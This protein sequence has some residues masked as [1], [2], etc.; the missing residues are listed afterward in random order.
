[1]KIKT[2]W[3][4]PVKKQR[5][6][7][8]TVCKIERQKVGSLKKE[9][10]VSGREKLHALRE[11]GAQLLM[12]STLMPFRWLKSCFRCFYCYD[13]FK[14]PK[15]LKSHQFAHQDSDVITKTMNKYWDPLVYVDV[16]NISCR[17]CPDKVNDLDTLIEH[18]ATNH[19]I[20]CSKDIGT[21]IKPFKLQDITVHCVQC[22][23]QYTNFAFL[24]IHTNKEH[25]G[26]SPILC[27]ICGQHFKTERLLRDHVNQEHEKKPVE[28][29]ICG[30][31]VVSMTR[32]RTHLQ[33]AH[34]KRYKCFFCSETF[35]NHYKRTRHMI[36][37]HKKKEEHKCQHCSLSFVYRNRLLTHI[38]EKHLREKNV[39]CNVCGWEGFGKTSL[40]LHMRKH[41]DERNYPCPSCDKAFKTRK[42]MR[43]HHI[44]IHQKGAKTRTS[45]PNSAFVLQ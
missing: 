34:N 7:L 17:I 35:E 19:Q 3:D 5:R 18:L 16:S 44:N 32:M 29:S 27:D 25:A 22:D 43:Q 8:K 20:H 45:L 30:E 41:S 9:R 40:D 37:D 10:G 31:T 42:N 38:R 15:D 21:F 1:M 26:L 33:R 28:C 12:K 4:Q 6:V 39:M 23:K 2:E 36:L 24:L 11:S 14:E 13:V